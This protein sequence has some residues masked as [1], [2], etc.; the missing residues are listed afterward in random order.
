MDHESLLAAKSPG[1]GL[2]DTEPTS[3]D[4]RRLRAQRL[5][6]L[7]AMMRERDYAAVVLLDPN[8]QRYATGSRNMFG[9]FLRNSTRYF[10]VPVEGPIVLFEYPQSA[11]VSSVLETV[12]EVRHSRIVWSSVRGA[13]EDTA[14]PFA[15]EIEDLMRG[16]G[17]GRVGLDR[18]FWSLA[19]ALQR[20]GLDVADCNQDI[21][22]ARRIKTVDEVACLRLSLAGSE[23]AVY[24]LESAIAVLEYE[25]ATHDLERVLAIVS[26]DNARSITLLEKLGFEEED[27]GFRFGDDGPELALYAVYR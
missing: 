6:R 16:L 8:N 25:R 18:C 17:P 24:A 21:L 26:R 20:R 22:H 10:F 15:D 14:G 11:H 13:D 19:Q 4:P 27:G 12:D 1:M 9:Y 3:F 7:R 2:T 23:A 5:E